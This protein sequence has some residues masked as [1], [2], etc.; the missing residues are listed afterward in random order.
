[1]FRRG[2]GL[3]GREDSSSQQRRLADRRDPRVQGVLFELNVLQGR[4]IGLTERVSALVD[5]FP[6]LK[7]TQQVELLLRIP[8]ELYERFKQASMENQ[9]AI[10]QLFS[11]NPNFLP[12]TRQRL[13]EISALRAGTAVWFAE[14]DIRK[15][16]MQDGEYTYPQQWDEDLA[17]IEYQVDHH[18]AERGLL[19]ISQGVLVKDNPV[20]TTRN[21]Y[22]EDFYRKYYPNVDLQKEF[23]F[24]DFLQRLLH[25]KQ[26][27]KIMP[28]S[29]ID[30]SLPDVVDAIGRVIAEEN[31]R[32]EYADKQ[33]LAA[34]AFLLNKLLALYEKVQ[35]K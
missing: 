19:T 6:S 8:D 28:G 24:E 31:D 33:H 26:A 3:G 22:A 35:E 29:E 7:I 11:D 10:A 32:G 21:V 20:Q 12:D 18:F 17:T 15:R 25:F 4:G 9:R 27:R 16:Y 2:E 14:V 23:D 30:F 5:S 13:E 34:H 1:M